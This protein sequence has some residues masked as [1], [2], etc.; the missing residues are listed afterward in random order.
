MLQSYISSN[1]PYKRGTRTLKSEYS[2]CS[3]PFFMVYGKYFFNFLILAFFCLP[4][5]LQAKSNSYIG[6]KR[7]A[8]TSSVSEYY[9]SL[10]ILLFQRLNFELLPRGI[11]PV[12]I[13]DSLNMNCIATVQG[14][15]EIIADEPMLIFSISGISGSEEETKK[16]AIKEQSPDAIVDIMAIKVRHFLEQNISGKLR[17]S[18]VPLDCDLLLNGIKIGKTPAELVL[19]QG[20]YT[21]EI[22]REYLLPYRDTVSILPGQETSLAKTLQFKGHALKPWVIGGLLF[23]GSFIVSQI[24]ESHF[25]AEYS[26]KN[27]AMGTDYFNTK[28][29][30][31]R[32]ANTIKIAFLIPM[33]TT[34]TITGY[35]I[36]E[37]RSLKK[38]IFE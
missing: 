27:A 36:L 19:E 13:A 5:S 30:Q 24:V 17:I 12:L 35:Q 28:W 31:Y 34:W 25:R 16:I 1:C 4:I 32:T 37:N 14:T 38:H 23:T 15:L 21:I 11:K 7:F 33:A 29:K 3:H 20:M 18:S 9:N 26:V 8:I 10:D 22:Q 6:I 2:P